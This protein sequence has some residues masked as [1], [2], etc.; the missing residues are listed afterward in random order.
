LDLDIHIIKKCLKGDE[1]ALKQLY[2]KYKSR[3]FMLCLRYCRNRDE[4]HDLLQEGTLLIFRDLKNYNP[5]KAKFITWSN[6]VLVNASIKYLKRTNWNNSF[7]DVQ[8]VR[9]QKSSESSIDSILDAE[10]LIDMIAQLPLGYRLVFNL[11]AI[12]GYS[13]EEISNM[14][15]IKVG[16]SKSQLFKARKVLKKCIE[17]QLAYNE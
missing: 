7:A 6:R 3:W 8:E 2:T 16:T 11:Y 17:K 9:G 5:N 15:N 1:R 13:H 10:Y 14:L 4:A 12:E